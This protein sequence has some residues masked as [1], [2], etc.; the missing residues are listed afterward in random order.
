MQNTIKQIFL[1]GAGL[2]SVGKDKADKIA[3]ELIKKGELAVKDKDKF[4]DDLIK[5]AE[6]T[7]KS[8]DRSLEA[9]VKSILQ[10]L[11]MPTRKD[12]KALERKIA[13]LEKRAKK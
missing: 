1:A 10:K 8:F 9:T 6:K 3:K 5:K 4:V 12:I 7:K 11:D 13:K 2:V